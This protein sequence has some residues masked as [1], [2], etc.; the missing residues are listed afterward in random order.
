MH[1]PGSVRHISRKIT[2]K[3]ALIGVG[4]A[5]ALIFALIFWSDFNSTSPG[6]SP[7]VAIGASQASANAA[8]TPQT[9]AAGASGSA[10]GPGASGAAGS[11]GFGAF[12][13]PLPL[14]GGAEG[15]GK[16]TVEL[17]AVSNAVMASVDYLVPSNS[18][19]LVERQVVNSPWSI[20]VAASGSGTMAAFAVQ[21]GPD[22]TTVT[23]RIVVDGVV[24]SQ[25]TE[26]GAYAVVVCFG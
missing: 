6:L 9:P 17:D 12:P 11:A 16:H 20:S 18:H 7:A 13:F 24:R 26:S 10:A 5:I 1:L 14:A 23:C 25:Q 19:Q 2:A 8:R 22:A 21:A 3:R 4:V 15:P